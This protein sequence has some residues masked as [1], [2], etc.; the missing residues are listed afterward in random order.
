MSRNRPV[1]TA[2]VVLVKHPDAVTH[3]ENACRLLG[4]GFADLILADARAELAGR[5]GVAPESIDHEAGLLD[6]EA[7]AFIADGG[8]SIGRAA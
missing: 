2:R 3:Q 1:L 6:D 5:L 8:M 4:I 7:R